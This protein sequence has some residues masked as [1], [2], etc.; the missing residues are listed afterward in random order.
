MTTGIRQIARVDHVLLTSHV[1][2]ELIIIDSCY[3]NV[4]ESDFDYTIVGISQCP[5]ANKS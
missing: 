1:D 4:L 2:N 3:K 5:G